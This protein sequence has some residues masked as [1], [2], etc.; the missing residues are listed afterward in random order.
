MYVW[1]VREYIIQIRTHTRSLRKQKVK[2]NRKVMC[3]EYYRRGAFVAIDH[4]ACTFIPFAVFRRKMLDSFLYSYILF[5]KPF[6][7]AKGQIEPAKSSLTAAFSFATSIFIFTERKL[8]IN[9]Q[10]MKIKWYFILSG[11]TYKYLFLDRSLTQKE[12]KCVLWFFAFI[13]LEH[14]CK[15]KKRD[16][17]KRYYNQ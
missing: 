9:I 13:R 14:F 2:S 10:Y 16:V 4:M 17:L 15:A 7:G 11:R 1:Q 5:S 12:T 3:N 8:K 6:S